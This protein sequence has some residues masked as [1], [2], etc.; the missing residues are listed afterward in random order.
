MVVTQ[1]ITSNLFCCSALARAMAP[2]E[3]TPLFL[4][5]QN[6]MYILDNVLRVMVLVVYEEG[7]WEWFTGLKAGENKTN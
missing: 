3:V 2:L 7:A 6:D 4:R 5:L 1:L